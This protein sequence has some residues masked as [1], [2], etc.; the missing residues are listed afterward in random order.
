MYSAYKNATLE[1]QKRRVF[2]FELL[3][4]SPIT[5]ASFASTSKTHIYT[6]VVDVELA[7][8]KSTAFNC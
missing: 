3:W 5:Q 7:H 8:V 6:L 2:L 1:L 4:A